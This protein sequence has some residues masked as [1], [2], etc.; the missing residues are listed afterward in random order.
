MSDVVPVAMMVAMAVAVSMYVCTVISDCFT[1][2][3]QPQ[4]DLEKHLRARS[5]AFGRWRQVSHRRMP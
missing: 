2:L 1:S 4:C 3:K 5:V